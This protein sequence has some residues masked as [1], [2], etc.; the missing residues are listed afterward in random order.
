MGIQTNASRRRGRQ[1]PNEQSRGQQDAGPNDEEHGQPHV[2]LRLPLARS[3]SSVGFT[4][5]HFERVI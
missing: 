1:I 2:P 4:L 3:P 5:G